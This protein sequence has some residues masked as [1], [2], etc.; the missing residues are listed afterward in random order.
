MTRQGDDIWTRDWVQW[1]TT[2]C[3]VSC[4]ISSVKSVENMISFRLH[5]KTYYYNLACPP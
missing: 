1:M 3:N 5:S 4:H 2:A